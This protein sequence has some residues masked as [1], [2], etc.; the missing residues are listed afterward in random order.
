MTDAAAFKDPSSKTVLI[1]GAGSGLGRALAREFADR[2][3]KIIGTGR[4]EK[5]LQETKAAIAPGMFTYFVSDVADAKATQEIFNKLS[6]DNIQIDI[7][8]NNAAI[9]PHEDFIDGTPE[10]WMNV[11]NINLGGMVNFSHYALQSMAQSGHGR[12][13][14]V[15]S[16]AGN[17]PIPASTAYSVS[18]GAGMLFT[19]ALIADVC[20]RFPDIVINDWVPGA[21]NTDMGI[22]EGLD[23][24]RAA[25]WGVTLALLDDPEINGAVF[26][27]ANERGQPRSLKRKIKD[28][29]TRA[30]RRPLVNLNT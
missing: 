25:K 23:P 3:I 26:I 1:T 5:H 11:I 14:N 9:Y 29:L 22:P 8:F 4:R 21:L 10:N 24:E 7:L 20:D 19:K 30:E 17:A 16:F 15:A 6:A 2:N 18:K 12:I 27:G 28:L 13:I